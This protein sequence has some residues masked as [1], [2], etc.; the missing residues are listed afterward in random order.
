MGMQQNLLC[1]LLSDFSLID[2]ASAGESR[3]MLVAAFTSTHQ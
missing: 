2:M 1:Y 3:L